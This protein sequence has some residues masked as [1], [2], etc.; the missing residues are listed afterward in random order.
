MTA[1]LTAESRSN[2]GPVRDE[3]ITNIIGECR[4]MCIDILPPDI[5]QSG[6][7]FTIDKGKIRFGLSAIKNVG[8]AA[9]E[10]ILS[11][12]EE[13][14]FAGITDFV[15]RV[16]T[17]KVNKKVIECLI[18]AGAFVR[19]GNRAG[20]L[21]VLPDLLNRV[22]KKQKA[23]SAGQAGLFDLGESADEQTS[24]D[25]VDAASGL[26]EFS[27]T[28]ILQS[29]KDLLGFYLSSHPLEPYC[30]QIEQMRTTLIKDIT[31]SIVDERVT[32]CG[33]IGS[34]KK[35]FT[36]AGN[37]EMA[38]VKLEDLTGSIEVV[39]FPKVYALSSYILKSNCPVIVSGRVD[40][41]DDKITILADEVKKLEFVK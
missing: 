22:H 14:L 25:T 41:K 20:Q 15:T 18:R 8:S 31:Q 39:V 35:I 10:S 34:Q 40:Q 38:F 11:A 5:N 17:G 30:K 2:T 28:E 3:K 26:E 23:H 9:I 24:T 13:K 1:V 19:F 37:N 21:S 12:R 7:E 29:E 32:V 36:K 4:R 27:K 16:D 6:V 33:S